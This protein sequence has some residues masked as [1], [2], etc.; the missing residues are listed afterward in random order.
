MPTVLVTTASLLVQTPTYIPSTARI[1]TTST[2]ATTLGGVGALSTQQQAR[3]NLQQQL[4]NTLG[5]PTT[6]VRPTLVA[7][8]ATSQVT[9]TAPTV[10][11]SATVATV[12][13]SATTTTGHPTT[14]IVQAAPRSLNPQQPPK[15]M[16]AQV[17]LP[18]AVIQGTGQSPALATQ[19]VQVRLAAPPQ[20][21]QP[22][23]QP[24]PTAA[25]AS[26]AVQAKKGLSLTV[27]ILL[28]TLICMGENRLLKI[29]LF[30]TFNI[31]FN[32][33]TFSLDIAIQF[34]HFQGAN[35][36]DA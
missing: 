25:G 14:I 26:Q 34:I 30:Q 29:F 20:I 17:R 19:A 36:I 1:Q 11:T 12:V 4:Q 33:K 10:I 9:T 22:A 7:A 18:G 27:S 6:I 23:A 8:G 32:I 13:T 3:K 16:T 35:V 2:T 15:I 31:H 28:F 21:I 5:Q 24:Q